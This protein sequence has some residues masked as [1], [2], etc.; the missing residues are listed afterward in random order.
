MHN[1]KISKPLSALK[2]QTKKEI[3]Q[4]NKTIGISQTTLTQKLN[5]N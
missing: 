3:K 2:N 1:Y 5:L 4:N